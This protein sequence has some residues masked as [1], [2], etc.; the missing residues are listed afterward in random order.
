MGLL[1]LNLENLSVCIIHWVH[2]Y[3]RTSSRVSVRL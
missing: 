1:F 3:N 2:F